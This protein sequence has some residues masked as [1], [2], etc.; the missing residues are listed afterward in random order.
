MTDNMPEMTPDELEA[1]RSRAAAA[2]MEHRSH[3]VACN[4]MAVFMHYVNND[5]T[6]LTNEVERLALTKRKLM[7]EIERL[8]GELL[9]RDAIWLPEKDAENERLNIQVEFLIGAGKKLLE[10][11][12]DHGTPTMLAHAKEIMGIRQLIDLENN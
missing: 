7:A 6:A 11:I 12:E 9:T 2:F 5:I 10:I 3:Y 8:N 1:I 4:A